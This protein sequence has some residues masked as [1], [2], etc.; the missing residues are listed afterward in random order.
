MNDTDPRTLIEAVRHFADLGVCHD[1]MVGLK[2]PDGRIVCPTCGGDKI[3]HIATRHLLRCN[4]KGCRKQF[5]AKV[6][7]LMEDSAL[8]L[9]AWFVA[10]W[11]AAN[12]VKVTTARLA[13]AL[14]ITYRSAWYMRHRIRLAS[15]LCS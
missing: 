9:S 7:T 2:W 10:I 8:P 14:S 13:E 15:K 1:Y 4:T 3:G 11:C 12:D 6:G 5:S